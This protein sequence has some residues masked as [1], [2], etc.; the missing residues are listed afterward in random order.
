MGQ[1]RL[2]LFIKSKEFD[3]DGV[4]LVGSDDFISKNI[5]LTYKKI[6]KS[7]DY[8]GI[9]DFYLINE[10]SEIRFWPGYENDRSNEPV[11]GGRF[12]KKTLL[13]K[14]DWTP[15]KNL[16]INKSLDY[17]FS[18]IIEDIEIESKVIECSDKNGILFTIRTDVNITKMKNIGYIYNGDIIS[19]ELFNIQEILNFQKNILNNEK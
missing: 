14:V 8:I 18:K 2:E 1:N 9:K 6:M 19:K 13:D 17:A 11:G 15:W 12:Y 16:E 7:Y 10:V 4:V 3:P 5:L